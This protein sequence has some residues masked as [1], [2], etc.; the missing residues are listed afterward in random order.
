[1]LYYIKLDEDIIAWKITNCAKEDRSVCFLQKIFKMY[2]AI[3][4]RRQV[5]EFRAG[6]NG[7][8]DRRIYCFAAQGQGNQLRGFGAA[9]RLESAFAAQ[10]RDRRGQRD[11][12]FL[13]QGAA[14]AG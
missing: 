5:H 11:G 4:K 1:M 14:G 12:V 6:F 2:Y 7:K 10:D 8:G 3:Q 9:Q 13:E